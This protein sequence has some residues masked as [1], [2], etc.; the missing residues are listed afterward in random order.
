[1]AIVQLISLVLLS[2]SLPTISTSLPPPAFSHPRSTAL[3]HTNLLIGNGGDEPNNGGGM[4]PSVSTPF[5][6]T[7]W[8]AQTQVHYVSATPYN[9]TLDKVMGF[10]GTRQPAIWMGES[11]PISVCPGVGNVVVD[12]QKRGLMVNKT[13][14]GEKREVVSVGYYSVEF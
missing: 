7:R 1:M 10:V 8:V 14:S 13:S 5:G 3:D 4:I 11:A 9:W 12:F 6:M 2:L